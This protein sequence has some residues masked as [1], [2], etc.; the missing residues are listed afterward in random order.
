VAGVGQRAAQGLGGGV[1]EHLA[2][3]VQLSERRGKRYSETKPFLE[4]T[5]L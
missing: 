5:H 3:V 1:G 4:L 2:H